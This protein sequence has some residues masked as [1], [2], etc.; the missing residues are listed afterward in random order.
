VLPVGTAVLANVY[1]AHQ[2][3]QTFQEPARFNPARFIGAAYSPYQYL[4]FGGGAR[5]CIG[6]AFAQYELKVVLG[7]IL[8]RAELELRDLRPVASVRRNLTMGPGNG[9]PMK[10][11]GLRA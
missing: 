6:A 3:E 1:L 9:I 2:R 11:I 8:A 7:T 5:R 4:P 10:V